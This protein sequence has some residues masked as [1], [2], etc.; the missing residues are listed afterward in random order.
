MEEVDGELRYRDGLNWKEASTGQ[1]LLQAVFRD[2]VLV[3]EQSLREIRNNLHGG[4][5]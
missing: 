5:F 2:G 4:N 1:N 3:K